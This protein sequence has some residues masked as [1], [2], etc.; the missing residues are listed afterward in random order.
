[1]PALGDGGSYADYKNRHDLSCHAMREH[2]DIERIYQI[3]RDH[4]EITG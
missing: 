3:M 2:I 1:L 4:Q